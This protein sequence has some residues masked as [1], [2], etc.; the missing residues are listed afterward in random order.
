MTDI[1][2]I[3]AGAIILLLLAILVVVLM[4]VFSEDKD[5]PHVSLDLTKWECTDR[6][7]DLVPMVVMVGKVPVTNMLPVERCTEY[8]RKKR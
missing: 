4:A 7:I 2:D 6:R 3:I 1:G 5:N 8:R